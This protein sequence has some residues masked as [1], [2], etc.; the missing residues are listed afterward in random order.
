MRA[1]IIAAGDA[2]RWGNHLNT[3]KHLVEVDGEPILNRTVRLLNNNGVT[4]IHIV[5]PND[6][7][8]KITGT[9]L[10]IPVKN[11]NYHGVD[12]FLNSEG[13]WSKCSR[14]LVMYG[15]VFYTD[16]AIKTIVEFQGTDWTLFCRFSGSKISGGKYGECFVQSFYP[17]DINLHKEKLLLVVES[18]NNRNLKKSGGWEHYRAMNEVTGRELRKHNQYNKCF[19]IDDFTDDFDYPEDY[20]EFI[21]R[22]NARDTS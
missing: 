1:I 4:D 14:T 6:D 19:I 7:R 18:V 11:P 5:G 13:L 16:E 15:D 12:K 2:T 3:P 9:S 21:K 20:D 17:K 22:W 10:F 8:Y